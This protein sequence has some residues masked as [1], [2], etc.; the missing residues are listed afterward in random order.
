MSSVTADRVV[1]ELSEKLDHYPTVILTCS[2]KSPPRPEP[3]PPRSPDPA[4]DFAALA[5]L[6]DHWDRSVAN[7]LFPSANTGP[8]DLSANLMARCWADKLDTLKK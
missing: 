2:P 3:R 6:I 7:R 8:I 4:N 1:V 5:I